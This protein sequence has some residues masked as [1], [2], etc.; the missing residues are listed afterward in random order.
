VDALL[1]WLALWLSFLIRLG[2]DGIINPVGEYLWL[3]MAATIT[4]QKPSRTSSI[5]KLATGNSQNTLISATPNVTG[6]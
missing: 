5:T 4:P 6:T 3:F 2:S 1:I